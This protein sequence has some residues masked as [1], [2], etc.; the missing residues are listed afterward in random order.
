MKLITKLLRN[1][2]TRRAILI[3]FDICCFIVIAALYFYFKQNASG[4]D[5]V[6]T[7]RMFM[8]NAAIQ[9]ALIMLLRFVFG[10]YK[11][12][13]RYTSTKA[14]FM[15]VFADALGS[16]LALVILR[17]L[18]T[19]F[20]MWQAIFTGS[21]NA[22]AALTSRFAYNLIYKRTS[23]PKNNNNREA[24][25]IVGAGRLG[26]YLAGDLSNN[27]NSTMEPMF[28]IDRDP[29]KIGNK[30]GG[31]TV[32]NSESAEKLIQTLG[33]KKVIIAISNK[34]S[35]EMSELY[36]HYVGLGCKVQVFDSLIG[37]EGEKSF[38][39]R[40]FNI[41]D[42]LFRKTIDI[43]SQK[44][45]EFYRGKKI[46]I[47]G[48]GG[49]IGSEICRQVAECEPAQLIIFDI[50]E[51]NAYEIQQ[52]LKRKYAGDLNLVTLIGSV[53][54]EERLEAIF[55][56][57]RPDIVFHAAAHKHVPLMEVSAEEAIKN[58][59][60]GTYNTANMAEKYGAEKF[61]L[62]STDKAVNP[63]N[64][65]G[66]S[67]R[68]CEMVVQCRT[69]SKTSF[70][71]VRFGNVLG[72][73]GS[74]I[75]LF[76]KQIEEGGP[77]TITDSRIIRYFMTI[78]EASQLVMNAGAM[79]KSGQL[80]VLDMGKPVKIYD[81]AIDMIKLSGLEPFKDI[82]IKEIG[83]RPG[84]KLYEELLIKSEDLEK[85]DNEKIFVERDAPLTREE[86]DNRIKMLLDAIVESENLNSD[87]IR[88]AMHVA[89]PTFKNPEEVNSTA[90]E[91]D[92]MR[93]VR[94]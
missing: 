48:G 18:G 44:A 81:L 17:L 72:S 92:E 57:Y 2:Y 38:K 24:V 50:Y 21:L 65:M 54:D 51:N 53:R 11:N 22:L 19:Y 75:P 13:W 46:L 47:T 43:R 37:G 69:D 40:E 89:V 56:K 5:T 30:V 76:K 29:T 26:A 64:V 80:F 20:G 4:I 84:E 36:Y 83:L 77:V 73:N 1:N 67:K 63:T 87:V 9:L 41:E 23:T 82:Q 33:I 49:S 7:P 27:P 28:Y 79:A 59:V 60:I 3:V 35:S 16:V 86:V 15:L 58:N 71:A 78:P 8:L 39:I 61:I 93:L 70:A 42:L 12:I 94:E 10:V 88:N 25:A 45:F 85:T 62:I 31:L 91:A 14:Y 32:Y 74:V 34:D 55:K 66:A 52:E 90:E 6:D 68:M